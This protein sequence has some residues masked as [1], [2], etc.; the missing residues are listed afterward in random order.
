MEKKE[1]INDMTRSAGGSF[2][3]RQWLA[4][5]MNLKDPKSVDRYL[6]GLPRL[7][8]RY[9]IGDIADVLLSECAYR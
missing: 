2:V 7:N 4:G 3:T 1:L 6:Y 8:K 9:F 5:Y